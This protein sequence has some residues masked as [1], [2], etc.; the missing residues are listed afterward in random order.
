VRLACFGD[1]HMAFRAIGRLGPT[2]RDA[3]WAILTGDL[4]RSAT[5]P[6]TR[7]R[8]RLPPRRRSAAVTPISKSFCPHVLAVTGNL[9]FV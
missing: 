4:T 7:R 2:L 9:D 5:R 3:D 6:R 8:S 1:I